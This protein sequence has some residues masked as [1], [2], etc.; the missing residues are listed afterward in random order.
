[1]STIAE[2]RTLSVESLLIGSQDRVSAD[3]Y[4]YTTALIT[5]Y[6]LIFK[7]VLDFYVLPK[8][9]L[10]SLI[11]GP[12]NDVPTITGNAKDESGASTTTNYTVEEYISDCTARYGNLSAE[13]FRLYPVDNNATLGDR[14]WNA[15]AKDLSEVGDWLFG[16][17]WSKSAKAPFYTY[18]WDHAP[19]GQNQGA[20]HQ[21]EIM[22]VLNALYANDEQYPFNSDEPKYPFTSTDFYIQEIMSGYWANFAKTGNP[23]LGGSSKFPL[24]YWAPNNGS[25]T[26]MQLGD[27]F[28]PQPIAGPEEVTFVQQYFAQQSPY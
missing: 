22:Y 14:S 5:G 15:A 10:Q 3:D 7:P 9:Y 21:S 13:Y 4:S 2:L 19:P 17:G 27:G 16:V 11:D 12:A 18:L 24:A 23:N 8:T 20:F 26:V 1:M 6:P 28:G 25:Q